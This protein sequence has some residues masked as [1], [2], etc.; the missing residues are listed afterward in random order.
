MNP[1][2]LANQPGVCDTLVRLMQEG[3]ATLQAAAVACVLA[4]TECREACSGP[5]GPSL[6]SPSWGCSSWPVMSALVA[7]LQSTAALAKAKADAAWA[8]SSLVDMFPGAAEVHPVTQ[9]AI[10]PLVALLVHEDKQV[11]YGAAWAAETLA[12]CCPINQ[13]LVGAEPGMIGRLWQ[14]AKEFTSTM[15]G[16]ASLIRGHSI[17]QSQLMDQD[18]FMEDLLELL[19]DEK[20]EQ[21]CVIDLLS[22]RR[23]I[24]GS[25]RG[26]P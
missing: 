8:M 21:S 9:A 16:F 10:K 7:V 18:S 2:Q 4:A 15:I 13:S 5:W 17:Y 24:T 26:Q 3:N 25:A 22:E 23:S 12:E 6:T 1:L 20:I 19:V 14:V 11:R